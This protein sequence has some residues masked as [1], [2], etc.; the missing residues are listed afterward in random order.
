MSAQ[1]IFPFVM[2]GLLALALA[3]CTKANQGTQTGYDNQAPGTAMVRESDIDRDMDMSGNMSANQDMIKQHL[4]KADAQYDER[5]IDMM[6]PHHE[7]AVTMA[8]DAMQKS[9][10]PE[11]KAMAQNIID[12]QQK[13]IEKLKTWRKEWYGSAS[14]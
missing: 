6:I 3:G 1:R 8:K 7:G 9:Q 4:G 11:I 2:V 5:F 12:S 14:Q 13:E 10:R